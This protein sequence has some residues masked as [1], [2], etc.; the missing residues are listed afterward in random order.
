MKKYLLLHEIVREMKFKRMKNPFG[1]IFV[2]L[3][4]QDDVEFLL[5]ELEPYAQKL[6]AMYKV[7]FSKTFTFPVKSQVRDGIQ[8][9]VDDVT[10]PDDYDDHYLDYDYGDDG[11]PILGDALMSFD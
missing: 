7:A 3:V 6:S 10:V 4:S 2:E 9:L 1:G 11:Q 8:R 5:E